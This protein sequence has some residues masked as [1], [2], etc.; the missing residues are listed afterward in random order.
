MKRSPVSLSDI[1]S[2]DNLALAFWRAAQGKRHRAEVRRF[3]SRLDNELAGLQQEIESLTVVVDSYRTFRIRDPKPRIIHAPRF[4]TRVLHHAMMNHLGPVLDRALVDDTYACREGRGAH[5]AAL[6]A[7]HHLRRFPWHV[8]F[9][10]RAYFASVDHRQLSAL[11]R[12]RFRDPGVLALCDRI[13]AS[14]QSSPGRGLPIGA[15]TSQ[16]FANLYLDRL[17]RHLL[18][19]VR[20]PGYVR[21]MDDVVCFCHSREEARA[22]KQRAH[23]FVQGLK[24]EVRESGGIR[25]SAQGLSF[26]GFR[27]YPG[28]LRLSRR[29]AMRYRRC[30][31][32]W[33]RAYQACRID[34]RELQAGYAAALAITAHADSRAFRQ[35]EQRRRDTLDV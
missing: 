21:Y 4:R 24:L 32:Y 34:A 12:R 27:V 28:T 1:A 6:R 18:Q 5:A 29:R 31:A 17:D 16:H 13:I 35:A 14:H 19:E 7:Q 3:A 22:V 26:V 9:D 20:V 10:M 25:R 11:F 23:A 30:W 2:R 8:K 15:L 33:E